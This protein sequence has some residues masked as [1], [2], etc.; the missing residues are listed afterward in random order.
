[1]AE[2]TSTVSITVVVS[3]DVEFCGNIVY[4]YILGITQ[5][6]AINTKHQSLRKSS[7]NRARL[8]GARCKYEN[9]FGN[10]IKD[11]L[12]LNGLRSQLG[13]PLVLPV[14]GGIV[15]HVRQPGGALN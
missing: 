2:R 13:I 6:A 10:R 11:P 5:A 7:R 15:C 4:A 3:N 8:R 1:M 14:S 9:T 12:F